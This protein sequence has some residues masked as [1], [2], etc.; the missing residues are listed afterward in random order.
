M[1]IDS[2][3]TTDSWHFDLHERSFRVQRLLLDGP[4]MAQS[5]VVRPFVSY[6]V[7]HLM[8]NRCGAADSVSYPP[9][10]RSIEAES[11]G[12]TN[13]SILEIHRCCC[14]CKLKTR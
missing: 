11:I 4:Q 10:V 8:R 1:R 7:A 13:L 9:S 6:L 2:D 5:A 3:A 14:E 12:E